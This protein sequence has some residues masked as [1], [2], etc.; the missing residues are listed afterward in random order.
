MKPTTPFLFVVGLVGAVVIVM[1]CQVAFSP[2]P[3]VGSDAVHNSKLFD[4]DPAAHY[5]RFANNFVEVLGNL[6]SVKGPFCRTEECWVRIEFDSDYRIDARKTD[7][8][9][10]PLVGILNIKGVWNGGYYR[11]RE[12]YSY[13][14]TFM[15]AT[16]NWVMKGIE[17]S[18][19]AK[20]WEEV[21]FLRTSFF[22]PLRARFQ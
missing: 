10:S 14:F 13:R 19:D 7:S 12:V 4:T 11:S 16:G 3:S 20:V 6:P 5:R 18:R 17:E 2:K 22:K 21:S 9:L 1:V 8:I 15:A